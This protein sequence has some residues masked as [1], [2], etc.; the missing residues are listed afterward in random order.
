MQRRMLPDDWDADLPEYPADAK[1]LAGRDAGGEVLNAV[2]ARVPWL[3]AGR[4]TS[5]HRT[6]R[7]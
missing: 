5:R 2:A 1:G 6:S 4:R 7:G 3:L